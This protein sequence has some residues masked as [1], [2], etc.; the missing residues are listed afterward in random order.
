MT[1]CC[2]SITIKRKQAYNW[3]AAFIVFS[4]STALRRLCIQ[5]S[6]LELVSIAN[7]LATVP[8]DTLEDLSIVITGHNSSWN[9]L[10]L[11]T[12]LEVLRPIA[13][14]DDLLSGQNFKSLRRL[15]VNCGATVKSVAN[16][17]TVKDTILQ[18]YLSRVDPRKWADS[19]TD[20]FEEPFDCALDE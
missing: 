16:S 10:S 9:A 11:P 3:D 13:I 18:V 17:S 19:L 12:L 7:S 8:P 4:E 2:S 15:S 5:A 6:S 1:V 20:V 14:L